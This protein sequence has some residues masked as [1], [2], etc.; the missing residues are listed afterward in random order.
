[1]AIYTFSVNGGP[2]MVESRDPDQPLLYVLRN[3]LGLTGAKF[4]CGLGQCGA[5]TVIIYGKAEYSCQIPVAAV[6]GR[7][8]T[9]PSIDV[10]VLPAI[11]ANFRAN[12]D[13]HAT[14]ET[15][16][17]GA[18]LQRALI[19]STTDRSNTVEPQHCCVSASNTAHFFQD[20]QI[21]VEL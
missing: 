13:L 12:R 21:L 10:A 4:G 15:G 14:F 5:C 18:I 3:S 11:R 6:A 2:R 17:D 8:I 19:V 16:S 1:M 7:K 20:W 9:T